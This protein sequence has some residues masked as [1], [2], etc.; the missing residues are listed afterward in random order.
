MFAVA[1][2]LLLS[3]GGAAVV[4]A[5]VTIPLMLVLSRRHPTTTFR[6]AGLVF[7]GLTAAEVAWALTYLQLQEAQPWIWF[8]PLLGG[9][10][11]AAGFIA[12]TKPGRRH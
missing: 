6:A 12:A 3:M 4:A 11:A 7:V 2:F 8:V 9:V 10:I 1:A 5:P